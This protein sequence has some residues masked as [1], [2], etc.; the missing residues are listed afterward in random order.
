M[1]FG[2]LAAIRKVAVCRVPPSGKG[3]LRTSGWEKF[4]RTLVICSPKSLGAAV[5]ARGAA[6]YGLS[7]A[8][9]L[10]RGRRLLAEADFPHL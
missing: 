9:V 1:R 4:R 2:P 3:A 5:V 7:C 8:P 6:V 10:R